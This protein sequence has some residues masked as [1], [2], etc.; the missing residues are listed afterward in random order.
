MVPTEVALGLLMTGADD[1]D[2]VDMLIC[3]LLLPFDSAHLAL[4]GGKNLKISAL[5]FAL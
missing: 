2:T 4:M 3:Y 1:A 5:N